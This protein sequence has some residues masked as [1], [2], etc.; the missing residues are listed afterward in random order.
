MD[1]QQLNIQLKEKQ[2]ELTTRISAIE[3]DFK[4]G[5]SQDFA[6]QATEMENDQVLT[7]IKQQAQLELNQVNSALSRLEQDE[8]GVC[9]SCG[10]HIQ[11]ERLVALPY[12]QTCIHCAQ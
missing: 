9:E 5:R 3:N 11:N 4:K 1:K 6:E 8:Y 12:V 2:I 7:E 10:N